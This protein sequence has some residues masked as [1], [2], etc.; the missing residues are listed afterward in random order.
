M[1]W[2]S[3]EKKNIH[4]NCIVAKDKVYDTCEEIN[5]KCPNSSNFPSRHE[6]V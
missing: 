2:S 1:Q 4:W 5:G 6:N 3:F